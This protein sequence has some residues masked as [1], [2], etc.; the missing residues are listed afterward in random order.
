[1]KKSE[2]KQ[3]DL[4]VEYKFGFHDDVEPVL[5]T[6]RTQQSVDLEYLLKV[7]LSGCW[8]PFEVL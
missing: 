4:E 6:G 5:S 3:F 1:M 8:I 2:P 7:S